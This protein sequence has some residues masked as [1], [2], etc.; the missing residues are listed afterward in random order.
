MLIP[1]KHII[2]CILKLVHVTYNYCLK[3]E[4]TKS[5]ECDQKSTEWSN[6]WC[7]LGSEVDHVTIHTSNLVHFCVSACMTQREAAIH[8]SK[9]KNGPFTSSL[10]PRDYFQSNPYRS[11][12]PLPPAHKPLPD[13][14]ATP[15]VPF[16]PSSLAKKVSVFIPDYRFS[17]DF[18]LMPT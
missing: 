1:R 2:Y 15:P 9:C 5:W 3:K 16:K 14:Q 8:H 13:T 12:K 4:K 6:S 17:S 10:H 11:N 18:L 7:S